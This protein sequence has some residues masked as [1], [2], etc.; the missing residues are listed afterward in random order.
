MNS[1]IPNISNVIKINSC[2]LKTTA[3]SK[4]DKDKLKDRIQML[5]DDKRTEKKIKRYQRSSKMVK[6]L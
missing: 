1:Q 6:K 2:I 4:D 5:K 3:L